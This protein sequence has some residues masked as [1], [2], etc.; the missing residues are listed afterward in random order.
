MYY[1]T[2]IGKLSKV[3][4]N[5]LLKGKRV[6]VKKGT[7]HKVN[8]T[9][10]QLYKFNHNTSKGKALTIKLNQDQIAKQGSGIIGHLVGKIH[11]G[12]GK[13]ANMVGL[14]M[15]QKKGRG[16]AADLIGL[17]HPT[18]GK[19]ASIVGLGAQKRTYRPKTLGA[20]F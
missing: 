7:A 1:E 8:L 19:L 2:S 14:G 17:V 4:L 5:N 9:Q 13:L 15:K 11:P 20:G 6:R 12:V 16:L 10:E 3:Q 18:A